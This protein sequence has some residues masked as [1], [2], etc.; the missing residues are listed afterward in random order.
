MRKNQ[1]R[2]SQSWRPCA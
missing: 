2:R 1:A